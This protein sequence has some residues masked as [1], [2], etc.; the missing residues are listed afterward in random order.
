MSKVLV[1]DPIDQVGI[2]ILSQVATVDVK[3]SLKPEE[4]KAIIGE[5]DALMIRSG[6][7]VTQEIIEAGTKLKIVKVS[8]PVWG[9]IMLM[10]P[11][12]L[13]KE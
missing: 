6:T 3:T 4:L 13:A 9:W 11:Q 7:R 8:V 1:S 10:L 2:D 12:L 5:Y